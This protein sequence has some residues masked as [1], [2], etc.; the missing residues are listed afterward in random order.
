MKN[1]Q[2]IN[3]DGVATKENFDRLFSLS[4]VARSFGVNKTTLWQVMQARYSS[5]HSRKAK[6]CLNAL[7]QLRL[8]DGKPVLV[9]L[10]PEA[11]RTGTEG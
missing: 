1:E 8:P 5:M 4:A 2:T 10:E 7:R 6:E 11:G 9:E 3:I